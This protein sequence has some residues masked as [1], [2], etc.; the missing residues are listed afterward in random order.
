M[1]T[2]L[3]ELTGDIDFTKINIESLIRAAGVEITDDYDNLAEKLIDYFQ[4]VET[5]DVRKLF[6]LV[7]LRGYMPDDMTQQFM[8]MILD[9][10][11]QI[12]MLEGAEHPRLLYEKRYIIDIDHCIIC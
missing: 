4:L 5:Y 3:F 9:R 12:L 7:N 1:D 6:I 11:Y 10:G 2:V 8:R